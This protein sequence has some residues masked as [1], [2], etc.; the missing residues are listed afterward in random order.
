MRRMLDIGDIN[1]VAGKKL[2]LHEIKFDYNTVTENVM[3]ARYN[4]KFLSSD[5]SIKTSADNLEL[6]RENSIFLYGVKENA[7]GLLETQYQILMIP[8]GNYNVAF[9]VIDLNT[10]EILTDSNE[11]FTIVSDTVTEWN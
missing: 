2:Y 1:S 9:V 8:E 6:F 5:S 11:D 4:A 3:N 7:A 10:R